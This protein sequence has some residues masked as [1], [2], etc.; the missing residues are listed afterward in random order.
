MI[1][2]KSKSPFACVPRFWKNLYQFPNLFRRTH[3]LSRARL[4][5]LPPRFKSCSKRH[6]RLVAENERRCRRGRRATA[7]TLR[8][9]RPSTSATLLQPG[10]ARGCWPPAGCTC[11]AVSSPSPGRCLCLARWACTRCRCRAQQ[12]SPPSFAA[13]LEPRPR[14]E[15][16]QRLPALPR[17]HAPVFSWCVATSSNICCGRLHFSHFLA[18]ASHV[19]ASTLFRRA[20]KRCGACT[21]AICC[22]ALRHGRATNTA[23][24]SPG[25]SRL[26]SLVDGVPSS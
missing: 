9:G 11:F 16:P 12:R 5:P 24:R 17:L 8:T 13:C 2:P 3:S 21:R 10:N 23:R 7:R 18:G 15:T 1:E 6:V 22:E 19:F 4:P 20:R 14:L 26:R 25:R